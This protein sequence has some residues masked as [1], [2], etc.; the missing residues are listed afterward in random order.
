M[1]KIANMNKAFARIYA[2]IIAV[3][4]IGAIVAISAFYIYQGQNATNSP[5]TTT[6]PSPSTS[7]TITPTIAPSLTPTLP[8]STPTP[9]AIPTTYP[10]V[11][12]TTS[13]QTPNPTATVTLPTPSPTPTIQP[14]QTPPATPSPTPTSQPTPTPTPQ[15]SMLPPPAVST[16]RNWAGF[17]VASDLQNPQPDVIGVSA[18]WIV[19][20]ITP[21][22][23]DAFSAVW[24]GIGGQYDQSLI[25]VG[26]EQDSVGGTTQ[27]SA[28]YELLPA[29]SLYI[30]HMTVSPG[31]LIQAAIKLV[32][33]NNNLWSISITDVSNGKSYQNNFTYGSSRLTAEWI[34]ERPELSNNV[35]TYLADFGNVTFTNC[36]AVFTDKSGAISDFPSS[37][38]VMDAQVRGNQSLELANVSALSEV[39][40]KFTVTFLNS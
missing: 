16:T 9:T 21:S 28:W 29:P 17:V 7:P 31:D 19:P 4:L 34:L 24:I 36:Q 38:V 22:S 13:T 40:T 1:N 8:I 18:S 25:Q 33:S 3:V 15:P 23:V 2:L 14:T 30:G 6:S 26:T 12:P 39:G 5:Q 32:D 35:L 20:T 11:N 10:T 27:Y 37:E